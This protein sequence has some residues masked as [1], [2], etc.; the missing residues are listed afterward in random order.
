MRKILIRSLSLTALLAIASSPAAYASVQLSYMIDGK[1]TAVR[2]SSTAFPL[3]IVPDASSGMGNYAGVLDEALSFWSQDEASRVAFTTAAPA[4]ARAGQDGR[5]VVS[6]VDDLLESSGFLAYT[7]SWFDDAGTLLESDIQVDRSAVSRSNFQALLGHE[8]G[9]LLG[10]DHNANL[11]STMYPFVSSQLD[12]LGAG[13]GAGLVALY[14]RGTVRGRTELR[15]TVESQNGGVF[16]AH[17]VAVNEKGIAVASTV[18]DREGKFV[19]AAL[20]EATYRLYA[21]PLDGPVEPKNMDGIYRQAPADFRTAFAL[22][23]AGKNGDLTITVDNMRPGLNPRWIGAFSPG[24]SPRLESI[25]AAVRTG[26]MID[27]AV[28]GDGILGGVSEFSIEHPGVEKVSEFRYGANYIWATFRISP[29]A[30]PGSVVVLVR[31]GNEAATLT[32]A[33]RITKAAKGP[34]RGVRPR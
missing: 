24:E 33:L 14:P 7:T 25:A 29:D 8:V 21:E 16:G 4:D 10:F 9:H 19:L 23:G 32:G 1:P 2:W 27:V 15:G 34:R 6:I 26:S 13:D 11:G 20:P 5:N 31:S 17:V 28:G 18:T 30:D 3:T 12:E 22:D